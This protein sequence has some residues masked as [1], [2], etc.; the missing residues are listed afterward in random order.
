[1]KK[2][3]KRRNILVAIGI[4]TNQITY[5]PSIGTNNN[6]EVDSESEPASFAWNKTRTRVFPRLSRICGLVF[7]WVLFSFTRTYCEL[8]HK[9]N[10]LLMYC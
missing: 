3:I 6:I 5:V 7:C 2:N 8:F 9:L 1:M 4:P 10:I